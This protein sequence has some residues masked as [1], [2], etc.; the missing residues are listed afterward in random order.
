[1][2]ARKARNSA[3]ERHHLHLW[4]TGLT[5]NGLPVWVGTVH[6]DTSGTLYRGVTYHMIAP[7]V[8]RE[9]D[10]LTSDLQ[11]SSCLATH[12]VIDVTA[13][14]QGQNILKNSFSTDGKAVQFVLNC[15]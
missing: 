15:S 5:G 1:M 4:T 9:R 6:L 8:D 12:R 10:A 14:M 7:D 2:P 11:R 13:Q 3:R